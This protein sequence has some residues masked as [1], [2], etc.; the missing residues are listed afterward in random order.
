MR[1]HE[2]LRGA[3]E[4]AGQAHLWRHAQTLPAA[5]RE[6]FLARLA[7]MDW[8]SIRGLVDRYVLNKPS[9]PAMEGLSPAPY[10][11]ADPSSAVRPYDA[12]RYRRAGE[13][14][15]SK[16]KVAAF[17]VAGGQGT[18][19]GFEGPK[20]C[21]PAT[22]V[23]R[24]PLFQVF[25]EQVLA[26]QR[27]Y[28]RSLAWYVMTSP[29]NHEETVSFFRRHNSFGLSPD[30]VRFFQQ[31]VMPTFEM[32]TGRIL[33]AAPG[34]PATNPDGHGGSLRAL[35]ESGALEEMRSRG[36]EHISYFQVD[37]PLV[38]VFDPLFI[39]LHAE[40]PDSSGQMSSKMVLK[41]GPEEKVGVF[42][43]ARTPRGERTVVI[44]YSDLPSELA[45]ARDPDGSLRFAAGSI[46]VHMLGVS[47]VERLNTDP[48]FSLPWHRAEKKTA[49]VDPETG[50]AIEPREP[51]SV[52]LE[53]F[54][55]DALE[56]CESSIVLETR[57]EEEFA[58]IKNA[59]GIDSAES[60]R[61]LQSARAARWLASAGVEVPM[62]DDGTPDCTLE[63]SP[64]TALEPAD[65][66]QARLPERIERGASVAI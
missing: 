5:L 44:E 62:K 43:R 55:F 15:L 27:R 42:C 22:P 7:E 33:L 16:G 46:A 31:G 37:N 19:L 40:A 57:R 23:R 9:L 39:G 28:G 11:P 26:A 47:F 48:S 13:R 38:K 50:R 30:D 2:D 36:V 35:G 6:A 3:L 14:L 45:R 29:L 1:A 51:N 21:Y 64:L 12:A 18:R 53:R 20:G 56:F 34:V 49:C 58:P 59:S 24:K 54:V 10:Y 4:A 25:A 17:V 41:T 63:I 8:A 52:K 65:L 60:S 61:A 32:G 66:K